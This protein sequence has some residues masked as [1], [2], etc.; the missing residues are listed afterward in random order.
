MHRYH[1]PWFLTAHFVLEEAGEG[2]GNGEEGGGEEGEEKGEEGGEGEEK[3]DDEKKNLTDPT[4]GK[5][6]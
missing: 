5:W 4:V 3:E 6:T 2:E 1:L